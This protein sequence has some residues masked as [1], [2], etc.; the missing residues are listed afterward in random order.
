METSVFLR[1]L[2]VLFGISVVVSYAFRLL[3]LSSIAGFLVAGAVVVPYGLK[4][5]SSVHDVEQMS[6]I[7]VMLLLF[8]I[9]VLP[10]WSQILLPITSFTKA[11]TFISSAPKRRF[12]ARCGSIPITR[13]GFG[14]IWAGRNIP[15]VRMQTRSPPSAHG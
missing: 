1:D 15:R 2:V 9:G 7:G 4:L 12:A 11:I 3:H 6:E 10:M 13:S 8:S 14:A 5:I